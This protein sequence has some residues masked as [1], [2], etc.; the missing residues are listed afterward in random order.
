MNMKQT[1]ALALSLIAAT[2]VLLGAGTA[3]AGTVTPENPRTPIFTL[4]PGSGCSS[5]GFGCPRD[6][7]W[8]EIKPPAAQ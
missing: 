2:T 4:H 7:G 8:Q 5:P 6:S 3:S 1:K